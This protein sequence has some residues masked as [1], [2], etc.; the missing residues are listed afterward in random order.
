MIL[1]GWTGVV[2]AGVP[3]ELQGPR[4]DGGSIHGQVGPPPPVSLQPSFQI[5]LTPPLAQGSV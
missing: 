1:Q 2:G 3:G 4:L 5:S